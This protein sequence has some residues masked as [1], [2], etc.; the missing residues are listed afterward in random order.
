VAALGTPPGFINASAR[1]V[2]RARRLRTLA[3]TEFSP[4]IQRAW[5]YFI[6]LGHYNACMARS[7]RTLS[8]RRT[9]LRD[10]LNHYLHKFV[11]IESIPGSSAYQVRGPTGM[12]ALEL[13]RD[14]QSLGVLIDPLN[15]PERP[16]AFIMGV[17]SLPKESIRG[18]VE[19]LARLIR[20]DRRLGSRQLSD[21]TTQPLKGRA[22]QRVLTGKTLLYN[23]VYG[24]PCTIELS[25]NGELVGRA[26]YAN[27][28]CDTGRWWIEDD[29]W[30]RQ[31]QNWAYGEA[32]GLITVVD[33][34]Q[35][36]WFNADGLFVDTALIV[37]NKRR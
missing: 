30:F 22:L 13:A 21:E 5:A 20:G 3:G 37:R 1:V 4:G 19:V 11:A 28:D 18:G 7:H 34:D 6:S 15:D 31:W 12:N 9:A 26:G 36:R 23:T 2:Q 32:L 17:T 14:A 35:V 8:L 29:R 10:A 27:E 16:E 33:G 25:A 24:E